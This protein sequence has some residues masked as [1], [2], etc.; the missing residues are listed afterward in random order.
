MAVAARR[1]CVRALQ[2][3]GLSER[4]ASRLVGISSGVLRYVGVHLFLLPN[5]QR[6]KRALARGGSAKSL[7]HNDFLLPFLR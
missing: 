1:E 6:W 2:A 7:S 5:P 4:A 3:R